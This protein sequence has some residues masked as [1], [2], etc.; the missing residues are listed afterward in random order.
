MQLRAPIYVF[1]YTNTILKIAF[2]L[3]EVH[4]IIYLSTINL[5]SHLLYCRTNGL[6]F[7]IV[8]AHD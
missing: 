7:T 6:I 2:N 3:A 4:Y 8:V 1:V 5:K